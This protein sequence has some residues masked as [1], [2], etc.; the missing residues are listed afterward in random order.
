MVGCQDGANECSHNL[1]VRGVAP[2][3]KGFLPLFLQEGTAVCSMF[4]TAK[5]G[6]GEVPCA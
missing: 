4:K 1:L 6:S 3:A 5:A 2:P